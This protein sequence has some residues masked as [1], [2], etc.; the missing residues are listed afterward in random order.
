MY[1]L[2]E[3]GIDI[4][5]K[6]YSDIIGIAKDIGTLKRC[7]HDMAEE[8]L[9]WKEENNILTSSPTRTDEWFIIEPV[10]ELS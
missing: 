1:V 10:R 6:K 7:A 5:Y 4:E 3:K 9:S 8:V 2:I